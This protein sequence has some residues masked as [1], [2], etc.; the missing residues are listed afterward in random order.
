MT[1]ITY[2]STREPNIPRTG[3]IS[4]SVRNTSRLDTAD[5][6]RHV[7]TVDEALDVLNVEK[8]QDVEEGAA[9]SGMACV[10]SSGGSGGA[11]LVGA[12]GAALGQQ[13]EVVA[14][15]RSHV[16]QAQLIVA[17]RTG[18]NLVAGRGSAVQQHAIAGGIGLGDQ[19]DREQQQRHG[20]GERFRGRHL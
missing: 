6:N 10:G 16:D 15:E 20:S 13:V 7:D 9:T 2:M 3:F 14:V 8:L 11:A 5:G 12:R 19:S 18:S 4:G 1:D 17:G